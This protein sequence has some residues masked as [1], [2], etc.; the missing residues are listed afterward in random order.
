MIW[1]TKIKMGG[2]LNTIAIFLKYNLKFLA[3][4][5]KIVPHEK[6][7]VKWISSL[8]IYYFYTVIKM[9]F[10]CTHSRKKIENAVS[11]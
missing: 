5:N 3:N 7:T 2:K 9:L 11:K 1:G 4:V 8:Y 6:K 10:Y